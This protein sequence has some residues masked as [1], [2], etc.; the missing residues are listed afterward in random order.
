MHHF[1]TSVK[2]ND[3][4]IVKLTY[5]QVITRKG[6]SHRGR[7]QKVLLRK[8]T[9]ENTLSIKAIFQYEKTGQ[10]SSNVCMSMHNYNKRQIWMKFQIFPI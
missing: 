9:L 3:C 4:F 6:K 5:P 8:I 1:C 7:E 10:D 2:M